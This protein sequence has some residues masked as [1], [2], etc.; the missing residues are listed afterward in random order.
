M[1]IELKKIYTNERF[2]EE[3]NCFQAEIWCDGKKVGMC[4]NDGHG[5]CTNYSGLI[6]H[7]SEDIIK[8]EEFCK[9]LPPEPSEYF[10]EGLP[11]NLELYLDLL[12]EKHLVEKDKLKF[13]KK[14]E[15]DML[16]GILVGDEKSYG[17]YTWGKPKILPLQTVLLTQQGRASVRNLILRLQ[18]EGKTILN[19]NLPNNILN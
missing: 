6:K 7:H 14:M 18:G 2:S 19:T 8:M 5:G 1:K 4:E 10:P 17:K 3:T 16:T 11:M 12:L 9:T 15:K 13:K